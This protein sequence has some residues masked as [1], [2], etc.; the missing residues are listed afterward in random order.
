MLKQKLTEAPILAHP[1]FKKEFILDTDTSD[2]AIAAVL[3][4]KI[5]GKEHVIAYASKTLSKCERRYCVTRKELLA[6]VNYVKH[7]RHYLYGKRFTL[8][9]DH[10]SL[11][12]IMNF[13]NP[14]GL[15]ARWLETLSSYDMKIEHRAGR[16]HGN[17][18]GLS[19]QV[20]KQCGLD[21][22]SKQKQKCSMVSR[23]EELSQIT[24]IDSEILDL[25]SA[26]EED[27]DVATVKRW[28][29][30]GARPDFKRIQDRNFYLKSLWTQ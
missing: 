23:I 22:K 6:V 4:Q 7:F 20:C 2:V 11:R 18:D 14:E 26:Q 10:G 30:E 9:T 21:C 3:S 5:D 8:H 25:V 15:V 24:A 1:D 12:W 27:D 17:A 16:L 13:K 29:S 19:R 28:V